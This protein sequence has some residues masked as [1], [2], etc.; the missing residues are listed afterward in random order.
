MTS[1]FEG[2]VF[3]SGSWL[4]DSSHYSLLDQLVSG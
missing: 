3:D 4:I 1:L 2:G